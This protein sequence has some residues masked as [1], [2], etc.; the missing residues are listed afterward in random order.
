MV[1]PAEPL[2]I[3]GH[4]G[5]IGIGIL[6]QSYKR[7]FRPDAI[8]VATGTGALAA[9]IVMAVSDEKH[10]QRMDLSP[11]HLIFW[12][13]VNLICLQNIRWKSGLSVIPRVLHCFL[14]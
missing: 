8:L 12:V 3:A 10:L 6:D 2:V 5:S 9:G 13:S 14:L 4:G 11:W 1:S 7:G